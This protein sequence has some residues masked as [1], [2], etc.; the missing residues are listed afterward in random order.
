MKQ[1]SINII[2]FLLSIIFF[3]VSCKNQSDK[4]SAA[5]SKNDNIV[6]TSITQ[7]SLTNFGKRYAEA[8]SSKNPNDLADFYTSDGILL[9]G[10]GKYAKGKDSIALISKMFHDEIPDIIVSLDS[11]VNGSKGVEFHW[12]LAGT[13]TNGIKVNMK[14]VEVMEF[15]ND[16]ISKS[17]GSYTDEQYEKVVKEASKNKK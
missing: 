6:N 8:W 3:T 5:A 12:S 10:N 7:D 9:D 15:R 1:T 16:L 14:G 13:N 2:P 17:Q 4:S 11:M